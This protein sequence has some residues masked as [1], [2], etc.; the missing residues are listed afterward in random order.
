MRTN[1]ERDTHRPT[2]SR[3]LILSSVSLCA[4]RKF[5]RSTTGHYWCLGVKIAAILCVPQQKE[6][7]S[8]ILKQEIVGH[9]G[10][11]LWPS[12]PLQNFV[13][14]KQTVFDNLVDTLYIKKGRNITMQSVEN[15]NFES[16]IEG[17]W[18]NLF[19]FVTFNLFLCSIGQQ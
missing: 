2:Y 16:R 19:I 4:S 13:Y 7:K 12:T 11:Y 15:F 9:F 10:Q 1:T 14:F 6:A 5:A 17:Y 8:W 18:F 3:P